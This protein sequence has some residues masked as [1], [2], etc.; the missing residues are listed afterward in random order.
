MRDPVV[1][2]RLLLGHGLLA[3]FLLPGWWSPDALAAGHRRHHGHPR[4]RHPDARSGQARAERPMVILDPGH[5]GKDPGAIGYSGTYEKKIALATAHELKRQL[6]RS[7]RYR[8]SMTR[9]TDVFIPL[10]LR[11]G[12]AELRRAALF[13]SMHADAVTDHGV[14]GAS[15]YTLSATASDAQTAQLAQREN[16]ADRFG[17]KRFRSVSPAVARILASLVRRETRIEFGTPGARSGRPTRQR[18]AHAAQ[19]G[20]P[21]RVRG[22]EGRR[23]PERPGRDGLHVEPAGRSRPAAPGASRR[24]GR[25]DAPGGRRL[26]RLRRSHRARGRLKQI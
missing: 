9:E 19:S 8:V 23:H 17:D 16:A 25:R 7:G 15:V 13:V 2:R 14:R 20:P 21:R 22:V 12:I 1:A 4:V 26:F 10:E 11:V 18:F 3:S 6:E 5:G 24:G